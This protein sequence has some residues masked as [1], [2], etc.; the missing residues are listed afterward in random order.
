MR[1]SCI[2]LEKNYAFYVYWVNEH[3]TNTWFSWCRYTICISK[4][5]AGRYQYS[6]TMIQ[7]IQVFLWYIL[8][9]RVRRCQ[10]YSGNPFS[11]TPV[12]ATK[13]M[14]NRA[15]KF[16]SLLPTL[17]THKCTQTP[18]SQVGKNHSSWQWHA[19]A[20]MWAICPLNVQHWV[21]PP[22]AFSK[23]VSLG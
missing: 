15:W 1:T 3:L 12:T 14:I 8:Y 19:V 18:W 21:K 7:L 9:W 11:S 23:L 10:P 6:N 4:K 2:I 5:N 17:R 16:P 13:R 22:V 20:Y